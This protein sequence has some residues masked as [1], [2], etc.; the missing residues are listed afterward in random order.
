LATVRRTANALLPPV[1]ADV[2]PAAE[3]RSLAKLKPAP[4]AA[5]RT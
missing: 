3:P 5:D 2:F 4:A 1:L